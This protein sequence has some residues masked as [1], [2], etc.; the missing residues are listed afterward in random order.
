MLEHAIKVVD[1]AIPQ[2]LRRNRLFRAIRTRLANKIMQYRVR[3]GLRL[4]PEDAYA[5]SLREVAGQLVR[6]GGPLGDYLEFGV[7]SGTSLAAA[8]HTL[9]DLGQEQVRF[10]G[11]D[12]FQGLPPEAAKEGVGVWMPGALHSDIEFTR[13]F[14]TERGVD[15]E[16]TG[17][18]EGWF[19]DTLTAETREHLGLERASVVMIDCDLYSSARAALRF[20]RPLLADHAVLLFD[21]WYSVDLRDGLEGEAR[22]FAEFAEEAPEF[23]FERIGSYS[24]AS[25]IVQVRRRGVGS[26]V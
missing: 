10:W 11:F 26:S 2:S 16:R 9:T 18:V 15:W 12:S 8:F 23:E 3:K 5:S 7:Y 4:V 21:D 22:A 6:R 13:R 25:E 24:P 19:S 20:A 1:G 17:L 14:L